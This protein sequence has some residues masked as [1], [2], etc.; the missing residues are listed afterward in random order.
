MRLPSIKT[1][2]SRLKVSHPIASAIRVAMETC[3]DSR[4]DSFYDR[5]QT[6]LQ[7]ADTLIGGHGV[8]YIRHSEDTM[9]EVQGIDYVNMGDPYICTLLFDNMRG[10][11]DVCPWGN[12]IE[13][14]PE[15][16]YP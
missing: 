7:T 12:I 9:R 8:E 1:I 3:R 2:E 13:C 5:V 10:T 6:A 14:A 4:E 15:G 11:F 16:S